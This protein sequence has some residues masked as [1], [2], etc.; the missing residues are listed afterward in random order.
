MELNN[1][2]LKNQQ[3][4]KETTKEIRKYLDKQKW[5]QH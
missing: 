4:K 1:I 5:K 3:V 2:L